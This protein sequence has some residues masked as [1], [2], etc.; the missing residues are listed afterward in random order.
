MVMMMM[1]LHYVRY[2]EHHE[3]VGFQKLCLQPIEFAKH[4]PDIFAHIAFFYHSKE[5]KGEREVFSSDHSS[6]VFRDFLYQL[7]LE[8]QKLSFPGH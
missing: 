2:R 4:I 6:Y 7:N 3:R 1:I 5:K 8:P